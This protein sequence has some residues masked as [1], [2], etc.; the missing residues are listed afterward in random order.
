MCSELETSP[1]SWLLSIFELY[2]SEMWILLLDF[3][4]QV[5]MCSVGDGEK[6]GYFKIGV[7]FL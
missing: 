5:D 7:V 1:E 2:K 4:L 6:K 3:L